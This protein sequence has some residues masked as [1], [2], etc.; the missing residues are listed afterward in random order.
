MSSTFYG[1][2]LTIYQHSVSPTA[3]PFIQFF[4]SWKEIGKESAVVE[5]NAKI[6]N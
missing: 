2:K 4:E 3:K 1:F 6:I 5:Q